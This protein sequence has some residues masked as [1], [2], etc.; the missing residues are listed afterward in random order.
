M[1]LLASQLT[2]YTWRGCRVLS[3]SVSSSAEKTPIDSTDSKEADVESN[4]ES[5]E[6]EDVGI[7]G[8]IEALL[9]ENQ[10]M[11]E[12]IEKLDSNKKE[13]GYQQAKIVQQLKDRQDYYPKKINLLENEAIDKFHLDIMPIS[14]KFA[15][16]L[17]GISK[18]KLDPENPEFNKELND[19]FFGVNM[20][21][22]D[23]EKAVKK[24]DSSED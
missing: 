15:Q 14:A 17:S 21:Y 13:Y 23:L 1:P 11:E 18:E 16:M 24:F 2:G 4:P 12:K 10:S 5:S 22:T 7:I 3:L 19:F 20:A 9:H 6:Q 8:Q